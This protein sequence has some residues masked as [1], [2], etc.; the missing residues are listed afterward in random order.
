MG[1]PKRHIDTFKR[2]V[3]ERHPQLVNAVARA[4]SILRCFEYA[5]E[6]LGNQDIARRTRLPKTTISRL[7]FTLAT[8]G[9]LNYSPTLGKYSLGTAVLSLGHAFVKSNDV[10]A[11]AR[12]LMRELAD[13]TQS[14]VMMAEGDHDHKHMVLLEACQGDPVFQMSLETGIR[15]THGSTALGRA[16]LAALPQE[17]F[18]RRLANLE[19]GCEPGFWSRIRASILR[20][21]QECETH[22]FCFSFGDWNPEVFAIGVPLVPADRNRILALNCSGRIS[23]VTQEK[24]VQDFGPK[25]VALRDKVYQRTRGVF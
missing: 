10:V 5:G 4:F 18:E 24:L 13:Y 22:G 17:I 25:L 1:S 20:A 16:A 21:R 6:P 3:D 7:T 8:L 15:V 11:I 9:C 14:A 12:P 23:T 19:R 2:S